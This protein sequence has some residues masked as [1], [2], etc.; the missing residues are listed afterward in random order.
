MNS[1]GATYH[2]NEKSSLTASLYNAYGRSNAYS[3]SF[4]EN[5]DNPLNT[6]AVKLALFRFVPSITYNFRF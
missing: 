2:I 4:R 3:I 5:E 6:E 1:L